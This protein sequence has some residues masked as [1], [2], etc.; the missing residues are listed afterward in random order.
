MGAAASGMEAPAMLKLDGNGTGLAEI[1][2]TLCCWCIMGTTVENGIGSGLATA[3]N[4]REQTTLVAAECIRQGLL[5]IGNEPKETTAGVIELL[6]TTRGLIAAKAAAPMK[7]DC[8]GLI[9]VSSGVMP[10]KMG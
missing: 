9:L 4:G 3:G 8:A 10:L 1:N 2:P 5:A 7:G 6:T